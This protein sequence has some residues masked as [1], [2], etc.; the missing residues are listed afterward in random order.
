MTGFDYRGACFHGVLV[1]LK[2]SATVEVKVR[3][4]GVS[5]GVVAESIRQRP[6]G[7]GLLT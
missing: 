2:R 5:E 7:W 6:R 4:K 1:R 3:H